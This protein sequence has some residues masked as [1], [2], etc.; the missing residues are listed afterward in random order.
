[1]HLVHSISTDPSKASTHSPQRPTAAPAQAFATH[2]HPPTPPQA[3]PQT[4]KLPMEAEAV[5]HARRREADLATGHRMG[6]TEGWY[7]GLGCGACLGSVLT[8]LLI[9]ARSKGMA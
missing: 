4:R 5:V 3:P 8:A 2:R 1:M 7:W 6:Y 9:L